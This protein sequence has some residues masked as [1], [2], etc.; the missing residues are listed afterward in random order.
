MGLMLGLTSG[1]TLG[2]MSGLTL[3]LMLGLTSCRRPERACKVN[4]R[5]QIDYRP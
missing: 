5:R 2:L 1:L 3:D 4:G